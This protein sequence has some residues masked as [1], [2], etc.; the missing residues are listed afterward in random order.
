MTLL[1]YLLLENIMNATGVILDDVIPVCRTLGRLCIQWPRG[2]QIVVDKVKK[3][4]QPDEPIKRLSAPV[5]CALTYIGNDALN[6]LL[7]PHIAAMF[8][9]MKSMEPKECLKLHC[10]ILSAA[11]IMYKQCEWDCVVD[12]A[13]YMEFGDS[14]VP[15]WRL[16]YESVKQGTNGM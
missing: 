5:I 3:Y 15:I 1:I 13:L 16:N 4:L 6:Q 12:R 8:K 7:W 11:S 14:L 9:C 2:V 10:S